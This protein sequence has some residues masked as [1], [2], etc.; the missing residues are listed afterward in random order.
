MDPWVRQ[1][2]L[3]VISVTPTYEANQVKITRYQVFLEFVPYCIKL[4]I[5]TEPLYDSLQLLSP[6]H[7]TSREKNF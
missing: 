2:G 7:K 5:Y 4:I 1:M 6:K 3:P